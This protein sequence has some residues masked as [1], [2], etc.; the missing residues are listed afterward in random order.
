MVIK[1]V[2]ACGD[3]VY[4]EISVLSTNISV[5]PSLYMTYYDDIV[6]KM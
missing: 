6:H 4:V 2:M 3:P 5:I 1:Y